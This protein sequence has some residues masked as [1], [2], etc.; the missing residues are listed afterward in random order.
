[1]LTASNDA[2]LFLAILSMV[3]LVLGFVAVGLLA[4]YV[5]KRAPKDGSDIGRDPRGESGEAAPPAGPT[6]TLSGPAGAGEPPEKAL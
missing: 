5:L 6:A 1:V 4:A 2:Q 3:V